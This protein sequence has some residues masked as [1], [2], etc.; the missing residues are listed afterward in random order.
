MPSTRRTPI[1]ILALV[2]FA[3]ACTAA[4]A[5]TPTSIP[6]AAPA[7]ATTAPP[8]PAPKATASPAPATPTAAPKAVA[9]PKTLTKLKVAYGSVGA[10]G[11]PVW[12]AKEQKLFEKYG[13][14]V[15]MSYIA[16][17]TMAMQAVLSGEVPVLAGVNAAQVIAATVEGAD[18]VVIAS[19]LNTTVMYLMV[20]P[21]IQGPNDLKGKALGVSRFG[22]LSHSVLRFALRKMG[23]D[24][25]K[26]VNVVQMGGIPEVIA[27]MQSGAVVGGTMGTP[28]DLKARELGY[29]EMMDIGAAGF[30]YPQGIVA[31]TR[32]FARNNG[33]TLANVL[34]A[35]VE[36]TYLFKTDKALSTAVFGKYT[37]T[38]DRQMLDSAYD[39]LVGKVEK[40]PYPSRDAILAAIEE[41]AM[42]NPKAKGANPDTFIDTQ[43]VKQLEDTGFIN[44]I[45]GTR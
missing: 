18:A 20:T 4:P 35:I 43:F 28:Q 21:S 13:L 19:V 9:P 17:A 2:L 27:G 1:I 33:P 5:P 38:D 44:Q 29:K 15:D 37:Q 8:A 14:D 6:K 26:D 12:I 7:I 23:L 25:E 3:S 42:T 24:P 41:V 40:V 39:G 36:G 10:H 11:T 22:S 34:R 30:P 16:G 32:T 45:Y 31:T